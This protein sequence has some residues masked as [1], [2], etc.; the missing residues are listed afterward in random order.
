MV[1]KNNDRQAQDHI[2]VALVKRLIA[3]QFQQWAGLFIRPVEFGGWD[4]RSFRLGEH[5]VVRLPSAAAYSL[6]VDKEQHW[7]PKLAPHLPL[8][9]PIPVARGEPADGY[10]WHWSVYR[11]LNGETAALERIT[12]LKEFAV[13]L[14]QFIKALQRIDSAGGP[15][16]GPH[17]FHR[18]G[19]LTVYHDETRQAIAA[20]N[21]KIDA[22]AAN[23]LWQEALA[24]TWHD[25]PV[26]LHGDISTGN[27][28]VERGQ[29]SAVIDFGTSGI[30]DPAC[31]LAIAWTFFEGSSREAFRAALSIDDATW[32]RGRGWALW[33]ALIVVAALPGT[34]PAEAEKSWR[35]LDEVLADQR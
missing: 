34:N 25:T 1:N 30:G 24:A 20:L 14:A 17:N 19:P 2:D 29:L 7:L 28:L 4:N 21:G 9:I 22:V 15:L 26:W 13:T 33:K 5:L 18:G 11:W 6:Q 8:S 12:N 10:P 16:A 3:T 32:A 23:A 35:V 27:L 31:D